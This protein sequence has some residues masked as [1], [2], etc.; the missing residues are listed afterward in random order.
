MGEW[1]GYSSSLQHQQHCSLSYEPKG[2]CWSRVSLTQILGWVCRAPIQVLVRSDSA[3]L[4]IASET[5]ALDDFSIVLG[6]RRILSLINRACLMC[7]QWEII[8]MEQHD[9]VSWREAHFTSFC[10][11][12][13]FS[14][15]LH[16]LWQV[17][18]PP[19]LIMFSSVTHGKLIRSELSFDVK[20]NEI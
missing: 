20:D 11:L 2:H 10:F 3:L 9:A 19:K 1:V 15:W 18:M 17:Y 5:A 13:A 16:L 12:T 6:R 14:R 7:S 8:N 4:E